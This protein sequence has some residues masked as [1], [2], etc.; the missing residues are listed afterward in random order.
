M[1]YEDF[2]TY[3]QAELLKELGFDL[4]CVGFYNKYKIASIEHDMG[5][6]GG[7]IIEEN[8]NN[9]FLASNYD[10]LCS[11]PTLSQVQKWLRDVKRII[12]AVIPKY[13]MQCD[14][15]YAW[16][17]WYEIYNST[18]KRLYA[19]PAGTYEYALELAIDEALELLKENQ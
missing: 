15:T 10:V 1:N 13:E 16:E 11:A 17:Y 19:E 12:I 14:G 5:L 7:M 4:K 8:Y 2:C 18:G 6:D 9:A 3:E